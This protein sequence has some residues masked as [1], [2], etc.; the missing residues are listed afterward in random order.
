MIVER[1]VSIQ[2]VLHRRHPSE[3]AAPEL[4]APELGQDRALQALHEAIG[5][6]MPWLRT[7][8]L[9]PVSPTAL[10]EGPTVLVPLVGQDPLYPPPAR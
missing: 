1:Q 5:P 10:I 9:D 4:D 8:V 7:G 2:G 6:R 3:E